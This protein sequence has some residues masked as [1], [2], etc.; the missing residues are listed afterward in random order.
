MVQTS[1]RNMVVSGSCSFNLFRVL[2]P[3]CASSGGVLT[4]AVWGPSRQPLLHRGRP[5][6]HQSREH[7]QDGVKLRPRRE[8]VWAGCQR[9]PLA[10]RSLLGVDEVTKTERTLW[11]REGELA[12]PWPAFK[13]SAAGTHRG[14][15]ITF[16]FLKDRKRGP[17]FPDASDSLPSGTGLPRVS[18]CPPAP[19]P[20][21]GN[22]LRGC[23]LDLRGWQAGD[24]AL[25]SR[26]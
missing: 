8:R 5:G 13:H 24:T 6:L 16:P 11:P 26:N 19:P 23:A 10:E 18:P 14:I 22:P 3:P 4:A 25:G 1:N 20:H 15:S 9:T 12:V 21:P 7:G 2:S 17:A